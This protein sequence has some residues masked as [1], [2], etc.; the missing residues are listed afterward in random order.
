MSDP[1]KVVMSAEMA[2]AAKWLAE[3]VALGLKVPEATVVGL[4][5]AEPPRT[6]AAH[7]KAHRRQQLLNAISA[8]D[9]ECEPKHLEFLSLPERLQ[10]F[11]RRNGDCP[12]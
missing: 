6:Y 7:N 8:G 3:H 10:A 12:A 9:W 2:E 4:F 11:Y 1:G 5:E